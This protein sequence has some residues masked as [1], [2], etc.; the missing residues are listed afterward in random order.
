MHIEPDDRLRQSAIAGRR[1][2]EVRSLT[3]PSGQA[4]RRRLDLVDKYHR[5]FADHAGAAL[6]GDGR[7]DI[8][9][10]DLRAQA[11]EQSTG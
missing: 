2:K 1:A 10:V 6:A 5:L 3:G 7:A 11:G 8:E 4:T 9:V